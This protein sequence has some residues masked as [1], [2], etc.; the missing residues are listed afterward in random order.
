MKPQ[1]KRTFLYIISIILMGAIIGTTISLFVGML[2]PQGVVK[3]F[4]LNSRPFGW[5]PF[6]L[7]M[8]IFTITT[9]FSLD[10]SV[11]SVLG[12]AI[13]WYFLRYFR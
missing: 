8:Q 7:N 6:T 5:D 2:L 1:T 3:D 9:G 10:I 13:S 11:T 4:F 12:M